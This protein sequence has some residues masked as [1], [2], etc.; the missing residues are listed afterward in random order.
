MRAF[1]VIPI[2]LATALLGGCASSAGLE[3]QGHPLDADRLS[4]TAAL[5]A[6]SLTPAAW[7]E[8]NWWHAFGDPQLD[9]LVDEALAGSPSLAAAEARTR[10]A[11]AEAGVANA[12][13]G[14]TSA[15]NGQIAG[16]QVPESL[17]PDPIGGSLKLANLVTLNL[18]YSPDLWG[19]SR[20]RWQA[21]VDAAHASEADTH[22]ARLALAANVARTYIALGQAFA[23]QDAAQAEAHRAEALAALDD[24][25]ARAGIGNAI[26]VRGD[27]SLAANARQQAQA[28]TQQIAHLRNAL[29]ALLGASPDRGLAIQR[30]HL[31][32]PALAVPEQ[33]PSG[34]L[35]RR[36]DLVAARWRV[37]A[38]LR[39]IDVRKAAFYP[40]VNLSAMIGLAASHV[41]DLFQGNPLLFNGGPALS[42][43][44]FQAK[45]LRNQLRTSQADYDLAVAGYNQALLQALRETAD[46]VQT[47]RALDARIAATR[48]AR[49]HAAQA[50]ALVEQR[51]RAGIAS[52]LDVLAAQ[53]PLLQLDQQLA[54][55]VAARRGAGI[56]L[57]QALG[58][59]VL[60]PPAETA[61][62]QIAPALAP[63][64]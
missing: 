20:N 40:S 50:H 21:A 37:E 43:P 58:G 61:E 55:L 26:R 51:H 48:D 38:A 59:G 52:R 13:R 2:L 33:I 18:R 63:T 16:L 36:P 60:A 5:G 47:A 45:A 22:A 31:A 34:L 6:N 46:A 27:R 35:A 14:P 30:P 9:A 3:T 15:I 12:A 23:V 28:A 32:T 8:S 41:E 4:V 1:P 56:D 25:R 57:V 53:Q 62:P 10:R 11:Q 42:L 24:A 17:A 54:G 7:P 39:G 19:A 44:V 64:R 49:E 29:A